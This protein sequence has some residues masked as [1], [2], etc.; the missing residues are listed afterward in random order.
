[1][2]WL[3]WR[4]K[5][6]QQNLWSPRKQFNFATKVKINCLNSNLK[7]SNR[8]SQV[9]QSMFVCNC[10][11][12]GT[13]EF[14]FFF[15]SVSH[16]HTN[17]HTRKSIGAWIPKFSHSSS[18]YPPKMPFCESSPEEDSWMQNTNVMWSWWNG[19]WRYRTPQTWTNHERFFFH[20]FFLSFF[21]II[22]IEGFPPS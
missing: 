13:I 5:A 1:M 21:K 2:K 18:K 11:T 6:A 20:S 8:T 4:D 3:K 10:P 19:W 15:L 22:F 12:L 9:I 7:G 16:V 17:T 14:E